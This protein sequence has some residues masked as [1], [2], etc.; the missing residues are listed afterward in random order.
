[1]WD[2]GQPMLEASKHNFCVYFR[3][4]IL[5]CIR[6]IRSTSHEISATLDPWVHFR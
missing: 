4:N 3:S 1:M 2:V 5:N 6:S